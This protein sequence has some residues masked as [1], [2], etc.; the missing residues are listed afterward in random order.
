MKGNTKE[1]YPTA[2]LSALNKW[3]IAI[4][5]PLLLVGLAT[6]NLPF[7][8]QGNEYGY[9]LA[10]A[11][12]SANNAALMQTDELKREGWNQTVAW[13]DKAAA[14]QKSGGRSTAYTCGR[15]WHLMSWMARSV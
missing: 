3:L 13:L 9:Y 12:A 11:E 6:F 10:Q 5:V 14:Y 7:Q 15:G 4:L 2:E 1:G 8:G